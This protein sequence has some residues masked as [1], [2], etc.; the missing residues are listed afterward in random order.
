MEE[1]KETEEIE[2]TLIQ[3][4]L[5]KESVVHSSTS[6]NSEKCLNAYIILNGEN[7]NCSG[8][9]SYRKDIRFPVL[10]K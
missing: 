3:L 6:F 7:C 2:K 5:V 1:F 10:L 8:Y 4:E 9:G